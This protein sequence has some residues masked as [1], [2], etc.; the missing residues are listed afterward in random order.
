MTYRE[1]RE[2]GPAAFAEET[3]RRRYWELLTAERS[4]FRDPDTGSVRDEVVEQVVCAACGSDRPYGGFEKDGFTYVRCGRCGTLYINPQLSE[5]AMMRFWT[6]SD[7]AAAW[8]EVL[9]HSAQR[10]FDE[11]KFAQALDHLREDG[12]VAGRLLDFGC[13]IGMFLALAREHGFEVAGVEPG[14]SARRVALETYGLEL[15]PTLQDL[16]D[17]AT[18]DVITSWEVLEHT[19]DPL[20]HLRALRERIAPDGRLL[21]LVG[22]N[23]AALANRIMRAASAAFDFPRFWYFRPE[24]FAILL[25]RADWEFLAAEQMLDEIDVASA[26]LGYGDP[27]S[28]PVIEEEILP[29]EFVN[30]L[31]ALALSNGMGY[32]FLVTARPA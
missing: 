12:V 16:G 17:D 29:Q 5:E 1:L 6:T 10:E 4:R 32:K 23:S 24:S 22:G 13:S 28:P 25:G 9:Q 19:K 11:A 2:R 26:Y 27:Y 18:F 8:I 30:A 21:A 14:E 31:R 20:S 15:V 3:G 7:V